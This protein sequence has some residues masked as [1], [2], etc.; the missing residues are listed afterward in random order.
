[1]GP[2]FPDTMQALELHSYEGWRIGLKV[3]E[4]PVPRPK[5]GQV[6]VKIAAAPVNP[7]DLAFMNGQYGVRKPLPTVPGWEGSGTVSS[8]VRLPVARDRGD[9][10]CGLERMDVAS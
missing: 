8:G 3:V 10:A 2:N 7:A 5:S 9:S 6:L 4:K 1:M